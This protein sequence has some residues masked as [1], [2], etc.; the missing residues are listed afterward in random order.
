M[1]PIP[2]FDA[3][4]TWYLPHM[5]DLRF[6]RANYVEHAF[7]PHVHDYF[8][9]G[10][11]ENG[12][13]SFTYKGELL[14]TAPGDLIVINPGEVH[15]GE[16]AI[17]DGFKYRA[18]YPSFA[19]MK[20]IIQEFN[21][22]NDDIPA[23]QGGVIKDRH[24][25]R[26]VKNLHQLS[27][28]PTTFIE[29]ESQLTTLFV[30]LVRRHS[31]QNL[32]LKQDNNLSGA[33]RLARDYLEAHYAENVTLSDLAALTFMSPYHLARSFNQH[34]GIPPHKYLENVRIKRAE[35]LLASGMPITDVAL[36]TGFSS[37]SH[38][39]RTFKY[40]IGTTPG[41]F[42]KKRKIV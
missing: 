13:Q 12:L 16:S 32:E 42:I 15:T 23:F 26:W 34:I 41:E 25:S 22:E 29:I 2:L 20:R 14:I 18:L 17:A 21:T 40:F 36:H 33:I 38:L 8:V 31:N 1:N 30:E 10:I 39:T 6:L 24:L 27:E 7:K 5:Y 28:N 19:L 35:R 11:I 9:L 3:G 4:T 37:Q